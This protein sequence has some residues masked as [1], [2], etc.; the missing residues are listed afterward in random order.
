MGGTAQTTLD[1]LLGLLHEIND[2]PGSTQTVN[3]IIA[4]IKNTMS[5]R[6][7]AEKKIKELLKEY[8]QNILPEI[9]NG[10]EQMNTGEKEQFTSMNNFFCGLHYL[11]S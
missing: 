3:K 4:N 7:V 6:H 10:W 5:D 8:R 1:T 2:M 9:V 11:V